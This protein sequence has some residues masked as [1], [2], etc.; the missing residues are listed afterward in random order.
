MGRR[1]RTP[2]R[3]RRSQSRPGS[4]ARIDAARSRPRAEWT[5]RRSWDRTAHNVKQELLS[6][7]LEAMFARYDKASAAVKTDG[8]IVVQQ[9]VEPHCGRRGGGLCEHAFD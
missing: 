1:N 5:R 8:A 2:S 4:P 3:T 9:D 6:A 7:D